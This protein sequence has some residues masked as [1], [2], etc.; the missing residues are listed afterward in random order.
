MRRIFVAIMM[1]LPPMGVY[2]QTGASQLMNLNLANAIE[3]TFVGTN[4]IVGNAV[5]FDFTTVG[6]Y[7]DGITSANQ[8]LK[9]R[10]NRKFNITIKANA[11]NFTYAGTTAPAPNMPVNDVLGVQVATNSTGG[12]IA[13]PFGTGYYVNMPTSPWTLIRDGNRGSSQTFSVKYLAYPGFNYPE[14]IYTVDIVYT[15]TQL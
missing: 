11:I 10:S 6:H 5:N 8:D 3:L 15:A 2:A 13:W 9:V 14:G 12:S 1:A 7:A 4:G